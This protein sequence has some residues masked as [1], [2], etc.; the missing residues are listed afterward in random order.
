LP[1]TAVVVYV[2]VNVPNV[3]REINVN[4]NIVYVVGSET[5]ESYASYTWKGCA[6]FM[7]Q[8]KLM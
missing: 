4:S 8:S 2:H 3:L 7:L 1:E 6:Q 5:Q